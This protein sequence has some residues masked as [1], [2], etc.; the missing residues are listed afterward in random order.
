[1]VVPSRLCRIVSTSR[2][3]NEL[4]GAVG[5]CHAHATGIGSSA[6]PTCERSLISFQSCASRPVLK[7][8]D[9]AP[10][11][12]QIKNMGNAGR[13]GGEYY[14]PRLLI[15]TIVRVYSG[16]KYFADSDVLL[17]KI[18]P[19]FQTANFQLRRT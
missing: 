9:V 3:Q 6:S 17:A 2:N 10:V 16:Y 8:R 4:L 1:M 11:R 15:R 13:N 18:T 19:C 7:A 12:R 5:R 14:T